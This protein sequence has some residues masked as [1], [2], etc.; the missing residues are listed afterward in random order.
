[1]NLIFLLS[2]E[3]RA[4]ALEEALSLTSVRKFKLKDS[5]LLIN[6]NFKQI[7]KRLAYTHKIYQLLFNTSQKDFINDFK[8]FNWSSVYK[9]NFSLRLSNSKVNSVK[10]LA[11]IIWRFVKNPKVKLN[12]SETPVEVIFTDKEVFVCLLLHQNNEKFNQRRAHLRPGFQ[13]I[14]LHPK[15]A[16]AL[17]NLT[18]IQKGAVADPFCGT[19]GILIEAGLMKLK[20]VGYDISEQALQNC[21]KNFNSFKIK[22]YELN[23]QDATKLKRKLDYVATDLPYGKNTSVNNLDALYLNFLQNLKKNLKKR[24]AVVFPDFVDYKALIKKSRLK[25]KKEISYYVHKSLTKKI[26]VLEH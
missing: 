19:G 10:E 14:S 18:G 9:S 25:I 4:L 16:R 5:L 2:G 13:P 21:K 24:A 6:T 7:L 11:G 17:I 3:N 26:V 22:N 15:L 1:M 8:S 12:N 20:P 23:K